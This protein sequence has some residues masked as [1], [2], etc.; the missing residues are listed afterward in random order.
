[1]IRSAAV[2]GW[3]DLLIDGLNAIF[4]DEQP[5]PDAILPLLRLERLSAEVIICLFDGEALT[6]DIHQKPE[7]LHFGLDSPDQTHKDYYK[8]LCNTTG[9]EAGLEVSPIP[10]QGGNAASR[11]I[12]MQ[13]FGEMIKNK[14]ASN[15]SQPAPAFTSAQ[16]ALEMIEGVQKVR[17][18]FGSPR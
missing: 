2:S 12:D 15:P 14:L 18:S 13:S 3:P 10:W 16:F 7:T 8:K 6:I 17:F 11:I 5:H 4:S 1:L 9:I